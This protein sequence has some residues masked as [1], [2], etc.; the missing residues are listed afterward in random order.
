[1]IILPDRNQPRAKILMPIPQ[2]DWRTP[3]LAQ[4]KDQF[5]NENCTRFRIKA[6]ANDGAV[7]WTGWFEDRADFDAFIYAVALGTISQE[8]ALWDLPTPSWQPWM[9]ELITYDFATVVFLTTPTGSNQTYTHPVDWNSLNNS[10]EVI[11]GGGNGIAVYGSGGSQS[12]TGGGGGAYSRILNFVAA[13]GSGTTYQIGGAGGDTWFGN[14]TFATASVGAKGGSGGNASTASAPGGAAA[15]GIGTLKYSGGASGSS[16]GT[17]ATGGGGAAGSSGNGN[18]SPQSFGTANY[19][20]GSGN[21]GVGGAAG[22]AAGG[23][24]GNGSEWAAN[25]GS[26]GGGGCLVIVSDVTGSGGNGGNYGGGGGSLNKT[27]GTNNQAISGGTAGFGIIVITYVPSH[28][29]TIN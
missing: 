3:S 28:T 14:T 16:T 13:K 4:P 25:F 12:C 18:A 24:G 21:A 10:I 22:A 9:G 1:M 8:R 6:R 23:A 29:I 26:G 2:K 19:P 15:S 7:V 17:G 20:G 5:G 27:A 11:G